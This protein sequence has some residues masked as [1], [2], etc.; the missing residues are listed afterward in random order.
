M[1]YCGREQCQSKGTCLGTE[2]FS[3]CFSPLWDRRPRQPYRLKQLF[4]YKM[5]KDVPDRAFPHPFDCIAAPI[6]LC[7][8]KLFN[9]CETHSNCTVAFKI[10]SQGSDS[11]ASCSPWLR[12]R[13]QNYVNGSLAQKKTIGFS[14]M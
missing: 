13:S 7:L 14:C 3:T 12:Q 6:F 1:V 9:I 5:V 11:T 2:K 10:I 4:F 8:L